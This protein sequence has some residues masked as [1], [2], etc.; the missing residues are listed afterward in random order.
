MSSPIWFSIS[1]VPIENYLVMYLPV[2]IVKGVILD[3]K[4]NL[5]CNTNLSG[6]YCGSLK[7]YIINMNRGGRER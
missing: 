6:A 1:I 4:E 2:M 7:F 5:F 3:M